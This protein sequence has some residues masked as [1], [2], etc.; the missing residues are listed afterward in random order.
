MDA[1]HL[2]TAPDREPLIGVCHS[3]S[4]KPK[5]CRSFAAALSIRKHTQGQGHFRSI[6]S[7]KEHFVIHSKW[8][9]ENNCYVLSHFSFEVSRDLGSDGW[10]LPANP[11]STPKYTH[12]LLLASVVVK[13]VALT[14]SPYHVD[15]YGGRGCDGGR[16]TLYQY[17]LY[18]CTHPYVINFRDWVTKH[19]RLLSP[20]SSRN[21]ISKVVEWHRVDSNSGLPFSDPVVFLLESLLSNCGVWRCLRYLSWWGGTRGLKDLQPALNRT[22]PLYL[23]DS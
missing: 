2:R 5:L 12:F 10:Q 18:L 11:L 22:D 8:G 15:D 1:W 17:T 6:H 23:T 20:F 7:N 4:L 19:H 21:W 14:S 13:G 9:V 3:S 16:D